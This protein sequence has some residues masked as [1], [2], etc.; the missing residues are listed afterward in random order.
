MVHRRTNKKG[1]VT[2]FS[3][4]LPTAD[5]DRLKALGEA[6]NPPLPLTYMVQLAV[7]KYLEQVP[8]NEKVTIE[9]GVAGDRP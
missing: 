1:D 7:T 8:Q 2:R 9:V 4:T 5:H 3:V 6:V